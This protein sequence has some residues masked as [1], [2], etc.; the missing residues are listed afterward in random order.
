MLP[1]PKV[2]IRSAEFFRSP[3][4]VRMFVGSAASLLPA[5][6]PAALRLDEIQG[7]VLAGF[8]KD[9][10]VLV[11]F[12]LTAGN[13]IA[14]IVS[15][16]L[17]GGFGFDEAEDLS[18]LFVDPVPEVGHAVLALRLQILAVGF[19]HIAGVDA[20]FDVVNIHE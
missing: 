12:A 9:H 11:F 1:V 3:T 8:S 16:L 14:T 2:R 13:Q 7:N 17:L 5:R 20:A 6:A 4:A 15:L 19:G 10:Q 18:G